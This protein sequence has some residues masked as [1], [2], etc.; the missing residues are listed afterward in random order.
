VVAVLAT[1][2][3]SLAHHAPVRKLTEDP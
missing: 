3:G 2:R 1:S